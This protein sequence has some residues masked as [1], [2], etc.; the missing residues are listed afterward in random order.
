MLRNYKGLA[1]VS[2]V[3]KLDRDHSGQWNLEC[4]ILPDMNFIRRCLVVCLAFLFAVPAVVARV[5]RVEVTSRVDV[6]GG[7]AFG[8]SGAY[9]RITGRVYFAV[10]IDNIHNKPIVD[11]ANAVNL[12]NGEVE[13]SADFVAVRPKFRSS[14]GAMKTWRPA[15]AMAGHCATD[16]QWFRWAGNGTPPEQMRSVCT[17]RLPKIMVRPS[18]VFCAA[19]SCFPRRLTRFRWAM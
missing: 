8:E 12:Q 11:L 6:L 5:T 15:P 1:A 7:K 17:L 10:R 9:E 2:P 19:T 14:M 3:R 4:D 13:F 16:S 18:A